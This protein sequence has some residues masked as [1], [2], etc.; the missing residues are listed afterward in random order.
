MEKQITWLTETYTLHLC[1]SLSFLTLFSDRIIGTGTA[2]LC[3]EDGFFLQIGQH[4][5]G[6][7]TVRH[8]AVEKNH[9]WLLLCTFALDANQFN[10]TTSP[11]V[12]LEDT[13]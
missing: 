12:E 1:A 6:V 3:S 11:K 4:V 9:V 10:T 7:Q 8:K 5:P 2:L 13:S